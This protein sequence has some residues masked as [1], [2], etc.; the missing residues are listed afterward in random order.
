MVLPHWLA[1]PRDL[2]I[3][4][5]EVHVWRARL[6]KSLNADEDVL[7]VLERQQAERF[8]DSRA[9]RTFV[10]SRI[11][12]RQVL[13]VYCGLQAKHVNLVIAEGGKPRLAE[14]A[15]GLR[16]NLSHSGDIAL[17]AVTRDHDIGID[18]ERLNLELCDVTTARRAFTAREL[19]ELLTL[20]TDERSEAFFR[21]WTRKEALLKCLGAGLVADPQ[22]LEVGLGADQLTLR[23]TTITSFTPCDGYA[24]AL[25]CASHVQSI[26][27]W[28]GD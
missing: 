2:R 6:T 15:F 5:S 14:E 24:A 28:D 7:S 11:F 19:T 4:D 12:L 26:R 8:I 27:F 20:P 23:E 18:V 21:C 22:C 10:G 16:F 3:A 25:A 1:P 9:R 13:S 17:L